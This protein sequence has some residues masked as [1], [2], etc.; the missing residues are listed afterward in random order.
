MHSLS[1]QQ[2]SLHH[3]KRVEQEHGQYFR[4]LH[5][6][7]YGAPERLDGQQWVHGRAG[8]I[9]KLRVRETLDGIPRSV[10]S[11]TIGGIKLNNFVARR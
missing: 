11:V 3:P 5:K 6:V 1:L 7:V 10:E 8:H 9:V 2:Y 4:T